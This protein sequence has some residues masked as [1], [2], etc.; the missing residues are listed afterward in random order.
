MRVQAPAAGWVWLIIGLGTVFRVAQYLSGRSLWLDEAKLALNIVDKSFSG[1]LQPLGY[2]AAAPVGF[3]IL[4]KLAV[5]LFGPGENSLR[6]LPL[7]SGILALVLVYPVASQFLESAAV[8]VALAL[9]AVLDNLIYYSSEV[10]QYSSDVACTLLILLLAM[11]VERKGLATRWLICYALVGAA[12]IWVSH[13]AI[14]VLAGVGL[15]SALALVKSRNWKQVG[16][17]AIVGALFLVSFTASYLVSLNGVLANQALI[18]DWGGAFFPFPP[19][20]LANLKWPIDTFFQVFDNPIGLALPGLG[21]AALIIGAGT[22]WF[23]D[24]T[25]VLLL[26]APIF[27]TLFASA[28]RMY[29]FNGRFL[30]FLVPILLLFV[31]EGSVQ[32]SG[33]TPGMSLIVKGVVVGLLLFHP[34]LAAAK[35]LISPRTAEEIRP[36]LDYVSEHRQKSDVVYAYYSAKYAL[37]YYSTRYQL[38]DAVIGIEARSQPSRYLTELDRL[39]GNERVWILFSHVYNWQ[40]ID[41]EKL[42]LD[43]L[44]TSGA[45]LDSFASPGAKVYLYDL[46]FARAQ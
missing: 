42:F 16:R 10:R 43:Y 37:A 33:K 9:F 7:L 27:V 12:L 1:L 28:L 24:R 22:L 38:G 19:R 45:R 4:E 30:L 44:D 36:V 25:K 35:H 46:S 3:L 31:A 40:G 23:R 34:T 21:A 39:R 13:P 8:T 18:D 15:V 41:E 29:P 2:D 20:S 32:V 6:L 26:S 14:F 5:Q 11:M 17:L